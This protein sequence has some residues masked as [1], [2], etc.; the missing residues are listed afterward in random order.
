MVDQ[1]PGAIRDVRFLPDRVNVEPTV[2]R[3]LT[4]SEMFLLGKLG[5]A[6]WMPLGLTI[7]FFLDATLLGIGVGAI[8]TLA[9]L[10]FGGSYMQRKKRGKPVNY[11]ARTMKIAFQDRGFGKAHFVR[12]NGPWSPTRTQRPSRRS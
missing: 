1:T 11:H 10:Y 7:C 9:T 4:N 2:F 12:H 5:L 6:I 3:G 8:L